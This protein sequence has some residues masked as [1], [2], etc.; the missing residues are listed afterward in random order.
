MSRSQHT[1]R[2]KSI[3]PIL[4]STK[5]TITKYVSLKCYTFSDE[6][7]DRLRLWPTCSTQWSCLEL[8]TPT[9]LTVSVVCANDNTY[10]IGADPVSGTPSEDVYSYQQAYRIDPAAFSNAL[11]TPMLP[12]NLLDQLP[13]S[14]QEHC[15]PVPLRRLDSKSLPG[16]YNSTLQSASAPV[17]TFG[18]ALKNGC[19]D[20]K[21]ANE[22]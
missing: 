4:L 18:A 16:P 9:S 7:S 8:H 19:S 2:G 22:K 12:S 6:K 14:T 10:V 13:V 20:S 5:F 21:C 1:H 11:P 17:P 3:D 15:P